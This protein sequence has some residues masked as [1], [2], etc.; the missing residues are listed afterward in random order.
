MSVLK[1]NC[2]CEIPI[3]DGFPQIDYYKL[4]LD[5]PE[6]WKIY[7]DGHTQSVFQLESYLGK[8]WSRKL[9]PKS[10]NDAAAL[11]SIIRPGTGEA[12]DENGTSLTKVFC[13]RA[14]NNWQPKNDKLEQLLKDTYGINIY[15]ESS[16]EICRELAG[17]NGAQQ[18]RLIKGVGKKLAD[19]VFGLQKEF[20]NGCKVVGKVNEDEANKIFENLK[21]S[22][23]YSFNRCAL[24][25]E[26]LKRPSFNNNKF[27]P[28]IEDLYNITTNREYAIKTGHY[29]LWKKNRLLGCFGYS[30]SVCKDGRIRKNK[31]TNIQPA[32]IRQCYI[33]KTE[34]GKTCEVTDN[35]KF[36]TPFG[37]KQLKDL[38]IGDELYVCG[39]YEINKKIYNFS[40]FNNTQIKTM[41]KNGGGKIPHGNFQEWSKNIKILKQKNVCSICNISPNRLE[42]HHKDGNRS[43]NSIS[44]LEP[45]CVSCH[46]K[47]EYSSGRVRR[48]EKGYPRL[49]EKIESITLGSTG[50]TYDITMDA[51]N[52]N[53]VFKSDII[54]CNSH[55]VGYAVTGYWTAWVKAHLPYHYICAWLRNAKN[56][57]KP[58]EE[59]RAVISE[60]RRLGVPVLPPSIKNLPTTNFFIKNKAVHFGIDSIKGCGA[61][62]VNKLT[63]MD[64]NFE[65]CSWLD[66]LIMYS[67]LI[68]KTQI[69]SMIR[70]GCFDYSD[71]DRSI[72]E[73]EY[74]QWALLTKKEQARLREI[75]EKD[76]PLTF[77]KLLGTYLPEATSKRK[78]VIESIL[79]SLNSPASS[80]KDSRD[81]IIAH[82][83]ELM[84]INISCSAVAKSTIPDA[85]D[86]CCDVEDA[87]NN[88]EFILVGEITENREIK[89]KN[90]KMAG[91]IMTSFQLVDESGQCSCVI[92]PKEL[93][94]YEG[95]VYD[96]NVIMIKGKKGN[97]G[98]II[99]EKVYE[100]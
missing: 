87:N 33:I 9:K 77:S 93:S 28:T 55:A 56:E 20:V 57:Q 80:L 2:G 73:Y 59:I 70:S 8:N 64:I 50:M 47:E 91:E 18:N 6:T 17:F 25:T 79:N 32:G 46:K 23:R 97:R 81:N 67:H 71:I 83:K 1:F 21:A 98:G 36:P 19:V 88:Q 62:G 49:T 40:Q 75:Y 66:F 7:Q 42:I 52:H 22:A 69:I 51:P 96:G 10:I 72:C 13:D 30:L 58:L 14:N 63:A 26:K 11:V 86:K 100:V 53:Y 34:S 48:G 29:Q 38:K 92:F 94:L 3:V 24:G 85:R 82:E 61:K 12:V 5:C 15:Q 43:N 90:G 44:N 27:E 99:T 60:A 39:K 74:N 95:A 16:M 31:I 54:S 37:D 35:H 84:G 65:D 68:N 4:N 76:L 45:L 41:R 89:I 78:L